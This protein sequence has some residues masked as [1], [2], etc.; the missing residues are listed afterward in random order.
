MTPRDLLAV[1][2]DFLAK[3]ILHR[4]EK[5]VESLPPQI[6]KRQDERHTAAN[7]AKDSRAKRDGLIS[8]VSKLKK[9]RDDAQTSANEI[10]AK[11]KILS[12]ENSSNRFEHLELQKEEMDEN[13]SLIS[14]ESLQLM[15]K[16]HENWATT[17]VESK[18]I[19][20]DLRDM[21]KLANKLL[22]AGKKAHMAMVDLSK[23]NN[24]MQSIWLENESHRR[25][26]ES[27]Y[28]KLARC[29]SESDTAVEFWSTQLSGNFEEMLIDSKRVS[30]GG[31]SSRSLMKQRSGKMTTRRN[32]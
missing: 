28:T 7:L 12:D 6:A 24:K 26:C 17:N 4:R 27:R 13:E 15:I 14:I 11:L 18:D 23:E 19:F 30:D 16:E 22:E 8:K 3:A 29:K 2:P 10:I 25:R 9:E 31:P 20:N 32:G 21:R 5:I 1:S